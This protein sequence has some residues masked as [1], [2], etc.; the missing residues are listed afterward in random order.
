MLVRDVATITPLRKKVTQMTDTQTAPKSKG[1]PNNPGFKRFLSER[2][3]QQVNLQDII[4]VALEELYEPVSTQEMQ[5]YLKNEANIDLVIHRVKYAL[6]QLV[7]ANKA[8]ARLETTEERKLRAMGA[9]TAPKAA[10]LFNAGPVSR[11]RTKAQVVEGYRIFDVSDGAKTRRASRVNLKKPI[12]APNIKRGPEPVSVDH[13]SA[14][15]FLIEKLV[16]ERTK[17]LQVQLNA[18]NEKLAQFKK[19][20]G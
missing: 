20:L 8:S 2:H 10:Y 1:N 5:R 6:E 13:S 7:L 16:A 9:H 4:H 14:I 3:N 18:A 19:L 12:G 11:P 17:E 15:D